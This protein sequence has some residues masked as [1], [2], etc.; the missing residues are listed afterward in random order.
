[1]DAQECIKFANENPVCYLATI[2]GDQPRVRAVLQVKADDTGFYYA[3]MSMKRVFDQL[4]KN[5]NAEICY[6]NNP[7]ELANSRMMRLTGKL[8][9]LDDDGLRDE[10]FESR[11]FLEQ[12]T[13]RSLKQYIEVF[14]LSAGQAVFWTLKDAG[15]E[16][17]LPALKF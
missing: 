1:M 12:I 17:D 8:E 13:G 3:L 7:S 14:R 5:P 15:G 16:R 10:A 4:K 6:F 9:L 2:D 11:A